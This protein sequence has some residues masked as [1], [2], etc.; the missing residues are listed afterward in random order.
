MKF[1]LNIEDD[2]QNPVV[3]FIASTAD[4]LMEKI[5]AWERAQEALAGKKALQDSD[6]SF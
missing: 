3:L 6:I 1:Y 4:M 5:G 2:E